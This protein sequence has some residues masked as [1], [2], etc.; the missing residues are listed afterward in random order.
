MATLLKS[1]SAK[2][3]RKFKEHRA[4]DDYPITPGS[5]T[6][7]TQSEPAEVSANAINNFAGSKVDKSS[8]R[9]I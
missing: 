1:Y 7:Y 8:F 2:R 3:Y 6:P 5:E 9:S 4:A